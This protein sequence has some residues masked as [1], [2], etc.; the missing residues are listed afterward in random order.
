MQGIIYSFGFRNYDAF[1]G[2]LSCIIDMND[3]ER[4][5]LK[6][7]SLFISYSP[8]DELLSKVIQ[9]K[10]TKHAPRSSDYFIILSARTQ[11]FFSGPL[12]GDHSG[13]LGGAIAIFS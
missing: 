2:V 9:N 3:N 4:F 13:S 1:L 7:L 8:G 11:F 6:I 10:N 5:P 12:F